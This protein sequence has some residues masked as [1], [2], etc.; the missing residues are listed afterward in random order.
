MS[1]RSWLLGFCLAFAPLTFSHAQEIGYVEDFSLSP[2]RAE[3]LKT[4]IPGTEDFYYYHSLHYQQTEQ[5]QKVDE[6]IPAWA[7]K[8][9]HT[10]R[11]HEILNR[12][13]LL[14]YPKDPQRGLNRIRERLNLQFNHQKELLG[15]KPNL[16]TVLDEK[17]VTRE[18]FFARAI[19]QGNLNWFEDSALDWLVAKPLDKDQR[20]QFLSRLQRPDYP[21]LVG[22]IVAD[23]NE[24]N[25]QHRRKGEPRGR[26]RSRLGQAVRRRLRSGQDR[27][28][29]ADRQHRGEH[30]EGR[31]FRD[32][33]RHDR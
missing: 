14:L 25:A 23:L 24:P 32:D 3:A 18:A 28:E 13:A 10:A 20:R 17:I 21:Q 19:A 12:Q 29:V 30:S 2:N 8:H 6:L 9:G 22:L 16:P 4:L 27:R 1:R 26:G 31:R 15:Q 11:V 33:Q 7:H 5:F